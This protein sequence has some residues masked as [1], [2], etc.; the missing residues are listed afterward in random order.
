MSLRRVY[1]YTDLLMHRNITQGYNTECSSYGGGY[2]SV[3]SFSQEINNVN[4]HLL[5]TLMLSVQYHMHRWRS[6]VREFLYTRMYV[7]FSLKIRTYVAIHSVVAYFC[8]SRWNVSVKVGVST[9]LWI[10]YKVQSYSYGSDIT[11][12]FYS[13]ESLH[14]SYRLPFIATSPGSLDRACVLFADSLWRGERFPV[15]GSYSCYWHCSRRD[16]TSADSARLQS[17]LRRVSEFKGM[18]AYRCMT[19]STQVNIDSLLSHAIS[20]C[21]VYCLILIECRDTSKL[22]QIWIYK[23]ELGEIYTEQTIIL[24]YSI[25]EPESLYCKSSFTCFCSSVLILIHSMSFLKTFRAVL[26]PK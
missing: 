18:N 8:S 5:W 26:R 17:H 14:S 11:T 15:H 4:F 13:H 22:T 20:L 10:R 1:N 9:L 12:G 25:V 19:L 16:W 24:A 7:S 3:H 2:E 6:D 21:R 23:F